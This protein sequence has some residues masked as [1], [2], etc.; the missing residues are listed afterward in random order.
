[1]LAISAALLAL[2]W[3]DVTPQWDPV[4]AREAEPMERLVP[5]VQFREITL[6]EAV[7]EALAKSAQVRHSQES[8]VPPALDATDLGF[9]Q[10]S[11]GSAIPTGPGFAP[12]DGLR[13]ATAV[14]G[15]E[16]SPR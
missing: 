11:F 15:F 12:V 6:E 5:N 8:I 16:S 14:R 3:R 4:P 7:K 10:A 13:Q 2:A 1:L 9:N